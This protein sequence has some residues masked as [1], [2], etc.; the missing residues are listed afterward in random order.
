MLQALVDRVRVPLVSVFGRSQALA[1][2][3]V[4]AFHNTAL[5]AAVL[6]VAAAVVLYLV[7]WVLLRHPP[8]KGDPAGAYTHERIECDTDN[9]AEALRPETDIC[10]IGA[11]VIGSAF[12][13]VM[14]RRGARVVLLERDMRE[15]DRIVGEL[16]QPS[17]VEKLKAIGLYDALTG[18]DAQC[19]PGS[20]VVPDP[21]PHDKAQL[22]HLPYPKRPAPSSGFAEEIHNEQ[23][24][25]RGLHNGRFVMN[26]R[27]LAEKAG[28]AHE[29]PRPA[30]IRLP[31]AL[32]RCARCAWRLLLRLIAC[33]AVLSWC[34]AM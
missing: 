14:A 7:Q 18:I 31:S 26:L 28:Y 29:G 32:T 23:F 1:S 9:S 2:S 24:T 6:L 17:G 27:R 4:P 8:R 25:G 34:T 5:F 20:G 13:A 33:C 16:L 11:G 30:T 10:V 22:I 12:A 3:Y 21:G 19:V 15:P